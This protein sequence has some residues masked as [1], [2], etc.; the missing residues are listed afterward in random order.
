MQD[1]L[2]DVQLISFSWTE[3]QRLSPV[4]SSNGGLTGKVNH[5]TL[6]R[7][8]TVAEP[9]S[10]RWELD[11]SRIP[12]SSGALAWE[13]VGVLSCVLCL[14][15]PHLLTCSVH[16]FSSSSYF[17]VTHLHALLPY[18]SFHHLPS[19][20]AFRS[21][22]PCCLLPPPQFSSVETRIRLAVWHLI[23]NRLLWAGP[24]TS[25]VSHPWVS[26]FPRRKQLWLQAG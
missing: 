13:G 21:Y 11:S 18:H 23:H 15:S 6:G 7:V 17:L 24:G 8:R 22:N 20:T 19:D 12:I 1:N 25:L 26:C 3:T 9:G 4:T 14:S 2:E 10:Q 5:R 16:V